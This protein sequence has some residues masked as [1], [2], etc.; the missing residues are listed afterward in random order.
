MAVAVIGLNKCQGL[1]GLHNFSGA[2]WGGKFV[3][4]TKKTWVTAYMKLDNTN[5]II[6]CFRELGEGIVDAELVNGEL[7]LSLKGLEKFVCRVYC[8]TGPTTL[9][10]LR[11]ELFRSKNL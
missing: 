7:P 2:D 10:A 1:V 11:W 9:A 6:N 8:L 3:G 5:P 4:I